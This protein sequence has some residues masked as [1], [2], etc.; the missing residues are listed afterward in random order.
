MFRPFILIA[1]FVA[2]AGSAAAE[3]VTVKVA[4]RDQAAIDRDIKKA[5]LKVCRHHYSGS[6]LALNSERACAHRVIAKTHAKLETA[7]AALPKVPAEYA[8]TK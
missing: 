3:D 8:T 7:R 5:A 4:G 2:I 1:G 6:I